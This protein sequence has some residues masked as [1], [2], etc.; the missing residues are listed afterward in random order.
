[1]VDTTVA[2]YLV[3]MVSGKRE[4]VVCE[5]CSCVSEF[6]DKTSKTKTLNLKTKTKTVT[7]KTKT[8]TLQK[9]S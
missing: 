1:M 8:K 9:L 4:F 6:Q 5:L 3:R 2:K 7:L